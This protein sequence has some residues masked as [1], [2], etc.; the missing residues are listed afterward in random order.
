MK[1]SKV[2]LLKRGIIEVSQKCGAEGWCPGTL[3]NISVL[4]SDFK[5]HIKRSGADLSRLRV[6]DILTLD[7]EGKVVE[8]K[9]KPSIE[10]NLHLGIYKARED[11]RAVFHVHPPFATAYAVAGKKIPMVTEAARI[12]LVDVPLLPRASP[13]S[14]KLATL[15]ENCFKDTR[16]KAAL[17]EEHGIVSAGESVEDAY[18]T[19]ALVEDTAKIA[20]LS[21]LVKLIE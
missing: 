13:G 11:I 18:H 21:K 12:V 14:V 16:V 1:D 8:G 10:T 7:V 9:G 6:S 2:N 3:G 17:L 4:D 15:V 20:L 19:A 5:V